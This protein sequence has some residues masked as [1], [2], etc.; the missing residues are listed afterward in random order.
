[1]IS[2]ALR[3][4][5]QEFGLVLDDEGWADLHCLVNCLGK[6]HGFIGLA[7]SDIYRMVETSAKKRHELAAGKIRAVY[8]HSVI[9]KIKR[10][11]AIPPNILFHGTARKFVQSISRVGLIPKGRQQV[12]LS[13]NIE[14]AEIVGKRRDS[15]PAVFIV[16]SLQAHKDGIAFYSAADEIWLADCIP[17]KYIKLT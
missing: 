13:A 6:D 4:A 5:P 17:A 1:M 2:Y 16:Y 14:T 12:H 7:E 15:V 9:T 11:Q 3:H 8:G 10:E